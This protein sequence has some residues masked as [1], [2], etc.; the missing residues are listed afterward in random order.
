MRMAERKARRSSMPLEPQRAIE[1]NVPAF[2]EAAP[3]AM[4]I[5]GQDG[6]ILLVNGQ[7]ERLFG[8][9]RTDLVGQPVE[10]LVPARY[11]GKHPS[12]RAEFFAD[13][14][15]RPMGAGVD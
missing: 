10:V 12:H 9:E 14:H 13:P 15:P 2:L 8:Y 5:V 6:R 3:D 7:A 11:R 4:V 1:A